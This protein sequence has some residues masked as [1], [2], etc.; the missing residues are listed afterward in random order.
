MNFSATLWGPMIS[1]LL[2]VWFTMK[3]VWPPIQQ[4][5]AARQQQ[6]ADGLAAGERGKQELEKAQS[7]V[8]AMRRD[9]R[10][11]AT[12]IINQASK[13]QDE[14]IE[15]ARAEARAE[16]DRILAAARE[17]V[18]QETRRAREELR[19]EV[20]SLAIQ[21]SSQILKRE[22]DAKAHQDLIDQLATQL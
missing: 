20:S 18:E 3:Y 13:R 22:V 5:L 21:A 1:F 12:E 17:E 14:M 9:A 11:Q 15:E 8:E 19:Q 4:A 6:I 16:A 7:E 2:F 10:E